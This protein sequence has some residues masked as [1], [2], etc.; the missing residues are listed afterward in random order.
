MSPEPGEITVLLR[1]WQDGD[2]NA[3]S[4]LFQLLLPELRKIAGYCFRGERADHTLQPTALINEA[5]LRLAATRKIEWQHR[6]HFL[7]LC[8]RIMRHLLIDAARSRG[9]VRFSPLEDVTEPVQREL[10]PREVE[11]AIDSLLDELETEFPMGRKVYDLKHTLG[12]T[13][14]Q[15]A[16]A[17]GLSLRNLQREWHDTRKWL[18]QRMLAGGWKHESKATAS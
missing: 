4:Q 17:L 14:E 16:E 1:R 10:T 9:T 5:F 2:K 6:G 7:A 3:E 11:I 18:F 12:L 15:A 13:D 8:A